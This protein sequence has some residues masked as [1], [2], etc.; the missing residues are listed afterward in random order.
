VV[1]RNGSLF[2]LVAF[3][4][5]QIETGDGVF[6][7]GRVLRAAI[8]RSITRGNAELCGAFGSDGDGEVALVLDPREDNP[9]GSSYAVGTVVNERLEDDDINPVGSSYAV[10]LI[11]DEL[12]QPDDLDPVSLSLV[13]DHGEAIELSADGQPDTFDVEG[14]IYEMP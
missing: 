7:A 13:A 9:V 11:V 2:F 14:A 6:E 5:G 4:E 12:L 3:A 1:A 8:E 10:G